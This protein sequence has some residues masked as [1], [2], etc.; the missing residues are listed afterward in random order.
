MEANMRRSN[1]TSAAAFALLAFLASC[2]PEKD[3]VKADLLITGGRL[4]N[5][6]DS[7]LVELNDILIDDG[8]ITKIAPHG[9][10]SQG[11]AE[12]AIDARGLY[13]MPGLIDV[14]AHLGH[15]GLAENTDED[16]E[17]ALAQFVRYGVTTIFVPG[18]GGGNDE[19]L[20]AWKKYCKVEENICPRVFGSG[21]LITAY[22]SH[23]I[24]TGWGFPADVDPAIVHERGALAMNENDSAALVIERKVAAGVDAIKI[25][26]EDGPGPFA[27]KPKMSRDLATRI[28]TAAHAQDLS[29]YAHVSLPSHIDDALAAGADGV[30]HSVEE[31]L[32]EETLAAM[33]SAQ[34]FFVPTLALYDGFRDQALGNR[35]QEPY[36]ASGVSTKALRSFDVE[37]YWVMLQGSPDGEA[38]FFAVLEDN[39]V[40]VDA[41]GIPVALGTDTNNPQVF[42]GYS[43]HEELSLMV[44][45]G[46]T[47]SS[48]LSAATVG[49]A[50]FLGREKDIG[51]IAV[52]YR[53]DIIG[54]RGNPLED[55]E[56]TRDLVLV[57]R[58]GRSYD[59]IVSRN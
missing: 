33:H 16:R 47:P 6:E 15:G 25:V 38:E 28:V 42:P 52:G 23:P 50:T 31:P 55:I 53:A 35:E 17:E 27:P 21:N 3:Q 32:S 26:I 46:L 8:V 7:A 58:D 19:Q 18:G 39:L 43:A 49:G 14:H 51:R 1:I 24:T 9:E 4:L 12:N 29:V 56:N 36:A 11:S 2:T 30:M 45:A 44:G 34:M 5:F 40:R 59:D 20:Q 57:V 54:M 37:D 48:A 13:L 10:I 41:A 22:G